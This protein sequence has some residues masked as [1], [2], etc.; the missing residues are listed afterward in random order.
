MAHIGYP[1]SNPVGNA[2]APLIAEIA[3]ASTKYKALPTLSVGCSV[4]TRDFA[5][6]TIQQRGHD[7]PN[8][9]LGVGVN[10]T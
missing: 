4:L 2:G 6:T 3:E 7:S 5:S 9:R 8:T 10:S 1:H